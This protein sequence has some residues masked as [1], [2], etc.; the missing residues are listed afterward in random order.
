[1]L[2]S[3]HAKKPVARQSLQQM[4][5]QHLATCKQLGFSD[6]TAWDLVSMAD[7][8]CSNIAEHSDA[9]WLEWEMEHDIQRGEIRLIFR[10]NGSAFNPK[11]VMMSVDR[12]DPIDYIEA[13]RH[14]GLALVGKL[15]KAIQYTRLNDNTNE[16][17]LSKSL[18]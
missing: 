18:N 17:V 9:A 15:A 16:L 11:A 13:D 6:E 14:I 4:R 12:A 8:I 5:H 1:M 10:D 3:F 7:E 2:L